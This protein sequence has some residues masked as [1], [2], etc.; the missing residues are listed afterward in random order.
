[1]KALGKAR[2]EILQKRWQQIIERYYKEVDESSFEIFL[3]DLRKDVKWDADFLIMLAAFELAKLGD[4][5]AIEVLAK[6][7]ISGDIKKIQQKIQGKITN[8][9][10]K[11]K[12]KEENKPVDFFVML[13]KV[14]K[15]GYDVR[16]DILLQ[17]WIGILKDIRETN[18]R[19]NS[20]K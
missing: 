10:L 6:M 12:P 7:G 17:E 14:R 2:P 20:K 11:Q 1:M 5:E 19:Q 15:E 9:E 3:N 16:S 8:H 18:E 13:A 4:E